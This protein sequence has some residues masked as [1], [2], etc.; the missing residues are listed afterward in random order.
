LQVDKTALARQIEEKKAQE[1]EQRRRDKAFEEQ[2]I[3]HANL[4]LF[5]ENKIEEVMY[6]L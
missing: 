5:L 1:Q 6:L 3:H 2:C 4:A